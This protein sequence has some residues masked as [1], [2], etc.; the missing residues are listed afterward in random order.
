MPGALPV[1]FLSK[2]TRQSVTV[3]LS[4]EGGD[5]LFG[6]YLTYRADAHGPSCAAVPGVFC[7]RPRSARPR[8]ACC[9]L[10]T[11]K[12]G[13]E[14][15]VKRGYSKV[16]CCI[17]MSPICSGT[18]RFRGCRRRQSCSSRALDTISTASRR[19]SPPARQIGFLNR[20]LLLDQHY[21]LQDNLLC[22]V[23]RMSM[24]HSLEVRPPL[25]DHRI[26]E[27]A[28]RLPERLKLDGSR[29]KI[30]LKESDAG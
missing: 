5:E 9:R 6:G 3:A 28:A 7:V 27:F 13:F 2:M 8:T 11:T 22:K 30:I 14:Y 26:V 21:Y 10:P 15:K 25:L 17:P 20:Y 4:G 23:D 24:A 18:A 12:I 29:Q 1:W 19:V 16:R